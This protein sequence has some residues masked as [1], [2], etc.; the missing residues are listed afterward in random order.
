MSRQIKM[1]IID[2]TFNDFFASTFSSKEYKFEFVEIFE[3][4]GH[5]AYNNI[6]GINFFCQD[7]VIIS[8]S[9]NFLLRFT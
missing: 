9:L 8:L 4:R 3:L 5:S 1:Q 6:H 7:R 2:D